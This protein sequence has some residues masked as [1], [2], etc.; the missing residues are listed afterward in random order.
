LVCWMS[1][2]G[3]GTSQRKEKGQGALPPFTNQGKEGSGKFEQGSMKPAI[4][5]GKIGKGGEP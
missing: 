1:F 3:K 2:S 4:V 5:K